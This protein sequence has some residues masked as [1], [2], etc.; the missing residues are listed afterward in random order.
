MYCTRGRFLF[1]LFSTVLLFSGSFLAA[2]S[3][4][5]AADNVRWYRSN[6]SGIA[7]ELIPSRLAALRNEYCLSVEKADPGLIPD[8]LISHYNNT[9][10]AELRILYENRKEI[11]SQ[12]IFRDNKR[13][14]R[15]VSSGSPGFFVKENPGD[16]AA[17]TEGFVE[18]RNDAG[19]ITRE[20]RYDEDKS[21][22]EF[23]YSYKDD[24]LLSAETRFK[25]PPAP[26][27]PA[28]DEKESGTPEEFFIDDES[29]EINEPAE[30]E[31][32]EEQEEPKIP[33]FVLICTD[34]YRYSRPGS[35][36]AIERV[37]SKDADSSV[38]IPFPRLGPDSSRA[39]EIVIPRMAYVPDFLSGVYTGTGERINYT[40]DS[41]GRILTEV[42][43]DEG[44][45]VIGEIINTWEGDRLGSILWK[46]GDKI[47]LVEYE[48]DSG[49]NRI[50][51][52][53]FRQGLLERSVTSRGG[54]DIE[55]I[56]MNGRLML[57]AVWEKGLKKSEERITG[58]G[59]FR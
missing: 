56:Y 9:F 37:L 3:S 35:L 39:E 59:G 48:Y 17:S 14:V 36:R 15:L 55:E 7:I 26:V 33:V 28:E 6:S 23:I 45:K 13:T 27:L 4:Y 1:F 2:Q 12:W 54:L 10:S 25:E 50:A 24:K 19:F 31:V 22:W 53:N 32:S 58:S 51:E 38:R 43:Q 8:I 30:Q 41:R 29:A 44:G 52:R 16:Q 11:R 21:E 20:L 18:I 5:S 40:I 47:L 34:Y 49:G 46:A 57:R 42:W